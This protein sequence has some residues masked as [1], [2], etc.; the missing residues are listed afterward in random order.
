[1]LFSSMVRMRLISVGSVRDR[2]WVKALPGFFAYPGFFYS[3][4]AEGAYPHTA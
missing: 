2:R 3:F 4:A 1:M